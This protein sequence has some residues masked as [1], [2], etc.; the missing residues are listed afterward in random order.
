MTVNLADVVD[1]KNVYQLT[2]S[3]ALESKAYFLLIR[4]IFADRHYS[5]KHTKCFY[6]CGKTDG[7]KEK[8][9]GKGGH[10]KETGPPRSNISN[11]NYSPSSLTVE[12]GE[13]MEGIN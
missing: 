4:V 10:K 7:K 11:D 2:P 12:L 9:K 8:A 13:E 5:E 1:N 3:Q 6:V